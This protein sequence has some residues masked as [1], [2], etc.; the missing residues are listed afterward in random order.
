MLLVVLVA[1]AAGC[2]TTSNRQEGRFGP[3]GRFSRV[4]VGPGHSCG[5]RLDGTVACWGNLDYS[6]VVAPDGS[7]DPALAD[8]F[9]GPNEFGELDAPDGTFSAVSAGWGHSCGVRVNRAVACW[10]ADG[11]G[12]STPPRGAFVAVSAGTSHSC[13]VRLDST[14]VCWGYNDRGQADAPGGHF[15]AVAAGTYESCGVRAEGTVAC[16]GRDGY[17]ASVAPDGRFRTVS[18]DDEHWCGLRVDD[19]LACWG[20]PYFARVTPTTV[21]G[22]RVDVIELPWEEREED[23]A[24]VPE[25]A[26]SAVSVGDAHS[27]AVRVDGTA[28]CWG[29]QD[30]EITSAPEGRFKSVDAGSQFSCGLRVDGAVVCWPH[31]Q[32]P[33]HPFDFDFYLD[34]VG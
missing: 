28:V 19:T 20:P 2:S 22:E 5:V 25:G 9:I 21:D 33:R 16:W 8:V 32:I 26:F 4:S 17:G 1:L 7:L 24:D 31:V 13:G 15:R 23:L 6:Q 12:Q 3:E 18:G 30:D 14:V 34:L 10:G 27:C 29:S 11:Y